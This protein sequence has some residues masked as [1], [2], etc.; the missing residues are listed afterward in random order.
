MAVGYALFSSGASSRVVT[1][2]DGSWTDLGDIFGGGAAEAFA[3]NRFGQIVG[4]A[5]TTNNVWH[6]FLYSDG[7]AFDLNGLIATPDWTLSDARGINDRGQIAANG[8]QEGGPNQAL[9]LFPATEIGRRVFRPEGTI[10]ELP[11]ITILQGAG[12]DNSGNSFFWSAAERKLYAIRPVVADIRWR[13]GTFETTTNE[14][15]FGDSFV[16]QFITNEVLLPTIS[17]N[18]WPSDPEIHVAGAPVQVEP[19]DPSFKHGFV[20]LI[21]TTADGA[22][23]DINTKV[24]NSPS[25]GYSVVHYLRSEGRPLNADLQPNHFTVARTILWN[26]PAFLT[27]TT[28]S[29]GQALT[30]VLHQDYPGLNGYVLLTNNVYYDTTAYERDTRKGPSLP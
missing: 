12:P 4:R 9:L 29:V 25:T 17:F 28:W 14:T 6:A 24:F 16:R 1:Y 22:Q 15:Q 18:A 19:K 13:T 20:E 11:H 27:N 30:N 7:R 26:D 23:V 2:V 21:Y 3:V 8:S 10:P 5:L